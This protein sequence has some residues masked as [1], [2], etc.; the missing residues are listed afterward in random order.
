MKDLLMVVICNTFA[1]RAQSNTKR[2][3]IFLVLIVLLSSLFLYFTAGSLHV[4]LMERPFLIY[5][6]IAYITQVLTGCILICS[7]ALSTQ[8]TLLRLMHVLPL[9]ATQRWIIWITPGILLTL[10]FC[11]V[12]IPST[13]YIGVSL[14]GSVVACVASF[15]VGAASGLGIAIG[16]AAYWWRLRLI[17]SIC[18]VTVGYFCVRHALLH[19]SFGGLYAYSVVSVAC[20]SMLFTPHATSTVIL[21][22][23]K[24][25]STISIPLPLAWFSIKLIRNSTTRLSLAACGILAAI[26]YWLCKSQS[27][28]SG[29]FLWPIIAMLAA[30]VA[31][32]LRGIIAEKP[33]EIAALKGTFFFGIHAAFGL[34]T[35]TTFAVI[36][37]ILQSASSIDTS[38]VIAVTHC[39]MG[40]TV[41]L[42]IGTLIRPTPR[43]ISAQFT[44]MLSTLMLFVGVNHWGFVQQLSPTVLLISLWGVTLSCFITFLIVEYKHNFYFWRIAPWHKHTI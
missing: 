43:D 29:P 9:T 27:I 6:G 11:I 15:L 21:S 44:T 18:V 40:I 5:I 12:F 13:T 16:A 14:G 36:P 25:M 31:S 8:S 1:I 35:L 33:P 37:L 7:P 10:L 38:L 23:A 19:Q 28:T 32:D 42:L 2:R 22:A 30:S 4:P 3:S 34:A 41:G 39:C 17:W 24:K 20:T 26:V